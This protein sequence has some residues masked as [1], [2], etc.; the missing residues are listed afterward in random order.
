MTLWKNKKWII[1]P[2]DHLTPLQEIQMSYQ[3]DMILEFAHHLRNSS[4]GEIKIYA[5]SWVSMNGRI[6]QRYVKEN[7][8]LAKIDSH[9]PESWLHEQKE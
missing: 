6:P 9:N 8:D 1:S 2:R 3:P 5:D 7:I 4:Q